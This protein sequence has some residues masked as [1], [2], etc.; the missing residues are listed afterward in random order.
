MGSRREQSPYPNC[1]V[2]RCASASGE[3]KGRVDREKPEE[4]LQECW[5]LPLHVPSFSSVVLAE[6]FSLKPVGRRMLSGAKYTWI[7]IFRGFL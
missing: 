6:W 2:G 7:G 3:R 5:E 1:C 4:K